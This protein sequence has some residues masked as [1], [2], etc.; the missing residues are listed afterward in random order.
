MKQYVSLKC[1]KDFLKAQLTASLSKSG[2]AVATFIN[3][4]VSHGS[5]AMF[6]RGSKKY[7]IYSAYDSLLFLTV[8]ESSKSVN[9]L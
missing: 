2:R 3:F 5:T 8:K 7:H 1:L 6:F 9:S 4:S